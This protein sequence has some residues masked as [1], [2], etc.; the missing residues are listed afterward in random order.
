[1]IS[2]DAI[3]DHVTFFTIIMGC[4]NHQRQD[5]ALNIMILATKGYL[6]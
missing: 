4:I 2:E 1:M 5:Q 6:N 3:P